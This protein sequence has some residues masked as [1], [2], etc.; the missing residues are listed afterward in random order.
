MEHHHALN[1]EN[2]KSFKKKRKKEA[3]KLKKEQKRV[4][5][6]E[7]DSIAT[8]EKALAKQEELDALEAPVEGDEAKGNEEGSPD[9][10]VAEEG[11]KKKKKKRKTE[12]SEE[13]E[14]NEELA[15]TD[16]AAKKELKRA[17]KEAKKAQREADKEA[18]KEKKKKKESDTVYRTRVRPWWKKPKNPK[19]GED[20]D[21]PERK[22]E[23]N[24]IEYTW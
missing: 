22:V 8:A 9:T 20:Y 12:E 2:T 18:R 16:K 15:S 14:V 1:F 24:K 23:N 13:E 3:K 11:K 17:D 4:A 19:I 5:K 21:L 6:A 7:Q 10:E